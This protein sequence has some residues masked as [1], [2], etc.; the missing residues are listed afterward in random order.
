MIAQAVILAAGNGTRM[1]KNA[2]NPEMTS[3]PKPL[4]EVNGHPMIEHKIRT[5][6]RNGVDVCVVIN[7]KFEGQFRQKLGQYDITYCYQPV[8]LGTAH[9]VYCARDFVKSELFFV[10]MGDDVIE[11]DVREA[12]RV[13]VPVIFGLRVD[14]VKGF[15][16]IEVGKNGIVQDILENQRSGKGMVNTG[17]YIMPKWFF[18]YYGEMEKNPNGEVG[19][20]VV[21][22][23]LAKHGIT[24]KLKELSRWFGVNTPSDLVKAKEQSKEYE[25]VLE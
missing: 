18:D 9:A 4:L 15:G 3:T 14:D 16:S 8:P 19:L 22:K 25:M 6:V 17:V 1:S 2:A 11:Y 10:M 23:T 21:P 24:F 20:N 5:L 12:L 7:P 13:S